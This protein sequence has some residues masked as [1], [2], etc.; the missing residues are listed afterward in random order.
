VPA[1]KPQNHESN[2]RNIFPDGRGFGMDI[3]TE[4]MGIPS[5]GELGGGKKKKD[6]KKDSF[7]GFMSQNFSSGLLGDIQS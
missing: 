5:F 3:A 2:D 6:D 4:V 1:I 7:S